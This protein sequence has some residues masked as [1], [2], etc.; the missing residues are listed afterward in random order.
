MWRHCG[1]LVTGGRPGHMIGGMAV[2]ASVRDVPRWARPLAWGLAGLAVLLVGVA[3]AAAVVS[4]SSL[5]DA[6]NTFLVTNTAMAVSFLVCGLILGTRRPANPIGWLFLADG[7]GHAV[8]AAAVP[9]VTVGLAERWPTWSLRTMA[10]LAAY[11]WPWSI[12]LFLPMAL[13]LFPDGR[14]P[15]RRWRWLIWAMVATVPLFVVEVGTEPSSPVSG[16]S[17][18]YLT[19][20]DHERF[21]LLWTIAELRV[22]LVYGA[23]LVALVVRYRR[24]GERERRQLLWLILATLITLGV[25]V[26]WG[27]FLVGPVLM[28]LAVPLIGVAVTVAIL[29]Y[30]LLDIRLVFSRTLVYLVLTGAVVLAYEVLVALLDA[31]LRSRTGLGTSV[32]ATVLVALGFNPVRVRLQ[33]LLGRVWTTYAARPR[34]RPAARLAGSQDGLATLVEAIRS[35]LCLPFVALRD[36]RGRTTASGT[37]PESLHTIPLAYG[38]EHLGDLLIGVSTD[39]RRLDPADRIVLELLAAPLSVAMLATTLSEELQRSREPANTTE[40]DGS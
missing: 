33:R 37:A 35:A 20:G 21:V 18:G 24:G 5:A 13:L 14:P 7:L 34:E 3:V 1:R 19:L 11:S 8:T 12:G 39:A 29:R 40:P 30:Q 31:V 25:L 9:L 28:L 4:G 38:A 32:F 2:E 17:V 23:A 26:P 36:G 16:G 10:T 22:L 27:V 6:V 15:G